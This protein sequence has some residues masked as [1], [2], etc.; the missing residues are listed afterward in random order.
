MLFL[1]FIGY[2]CLCMV[3]EMV[4][5]CVICEE[6]VVFGVDDIEVGERF[7]FCVIFGCKIKDN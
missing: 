5:F 4:L 1:D 7:W 2:E 6:V 3:V